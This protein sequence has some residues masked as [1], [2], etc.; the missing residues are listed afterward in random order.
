MKITVNLTKA[1]L[2]LIEEAILQYQNLLMK[3]EEEEEIIKY[4]LGLAKRVLSEFGM[5][6]LEEEVE[7]EQAVQQ[8]QQ[9]ASNHPYPPQGGMP[10][11]H[12]NHPQQNYQGQNTFVP[13][14]Q[15]PFSR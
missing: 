8:Q 1:E 3:S 14:N 11:G 13:P 4:E 5:E 10:Y 12:S 9:M 7:E 15:Y 6:E 2:D